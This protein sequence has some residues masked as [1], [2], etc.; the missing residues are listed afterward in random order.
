[1]SASKYL[2]QQ[3]GGLGQPETGGKVREAARA[4]GPQLEPLP[5]SA[6]PGPGACPLLQIPPLAYSIVD[7]GTPATVD[8]MRASEVR[9]IGGMTGRDLWPPR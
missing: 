7:L 4:A 1:M 9:L 5:N 2:E 8:F 6:F 3:Y